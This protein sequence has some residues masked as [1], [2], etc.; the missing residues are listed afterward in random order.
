L[1]ALLGT[2]TEAYVLALARV[3]GF[4]LLLPGFSSL[5]VPVRVRAMIAAALAV[6]LAPLLP[7]VRPAAEV[8]AASP[9]WAMLASTEIMIGLTLGFLVRLHFLALAFA[10]ATLSALRRRPACRLTAMKPSRRC[11]R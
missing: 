1:I 5:R 10:G 11:K 6:C 7:Q 9:A 2:S 8:V 4:I 3:S